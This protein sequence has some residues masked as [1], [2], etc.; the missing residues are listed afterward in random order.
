MA[1]AVYCSGSLHPLA[2]LTSCYL[3]VYCPFNY[4]V[5][6]SFKASDSAAANTCCS[7][8]ACVSRFPGRARLCACLTRINSNVRHVLDQWC[9]SSK[10]ASLQLIKALQ[11]DY[12]PKQCPNPSH[13]VDTEVQPYLQLPCCGYGTRSS[14]SAEGDLCVIGFDSDVEYCHRGHFY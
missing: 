13:D 2:V 1:S 11:N 5:A 6:E 8:C 3:L 14:G 12:N 9:S 4:N 10:M 7:L